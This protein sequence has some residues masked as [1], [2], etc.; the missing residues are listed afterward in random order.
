[1][2]YGFMGLWVYGFM[3]LWVYGFMG[4]WVRASEIHDVA[5]NRR[6][7]YANILVTFPLCHTDD[8]AQK[9]G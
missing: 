4:L 2:V 9:R 7:I 1:M 6:K 5:I 8:I 3:G